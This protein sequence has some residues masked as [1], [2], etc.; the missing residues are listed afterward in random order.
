M[1]ARAHAPHDKGKA[2]LVVTEA[3]GESGEVF[4]AKSNDAT[5]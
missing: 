1:Q 5:A 3:A 4:P 2:H